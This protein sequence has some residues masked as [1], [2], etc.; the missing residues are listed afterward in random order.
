[1]FAVFAQR[2]ERALFLEHLVAEADARRRRENNTLTVN[3]NSHFAAGQR[4]KGT[5]ADRCKVE[6]SC[7]FMIFCRFIV[8]PFYTVTLFSPWHFVHNYY[9]NISYSHFQ[10]VIWVTNMIGCLS[11]IVSYK[12]NSTLCV[13]A[14][15]CILSSGM[16]VHLL[17]F[18][19]YTVHW[20]NIVSMWDGHLGPVLL[21]FGGDVAVINGQVC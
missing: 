9:K 8:T 1:M 21:G 10:Q 13:R 11:F 18:V 17:L 12:E 5:K 3:Q 6:T 4:N 20:L 19:V 14:C 15:M 16:K 2:L 7:R